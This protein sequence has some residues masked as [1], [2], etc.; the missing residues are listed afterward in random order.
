MLEPGVSL[1]LDR[2]AFVTEFPPLLI[3]VLLLDPYCCPVIIL[4]TAHFVVEHDV[5]VDLDTCVRA[6]AMQSPDRLL[7][8]CF[9]AIIIIASSFI[10][11][12]WLSLS[13]RPIYD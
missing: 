3:A 8:F 13:A 6:V 9:G 4:R 11:T 12:L 1:G 10:L 2:A 5:R 7:E